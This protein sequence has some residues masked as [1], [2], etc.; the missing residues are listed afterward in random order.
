MVMPELATTEG[1]SC[2]SGTRWPAGP[3]PGLRWA[4]R[5]ASRCRVRLPWPKLWVLADASADAHALHSACGVQPLVPLVG[6]VGV[7]FTHQDE[8]QPL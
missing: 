8:V 7:G 6:L 3:G 4:N 5:K 1:E 2:K